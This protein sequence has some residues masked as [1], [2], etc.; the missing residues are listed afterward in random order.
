MVAF[1]IGYDAGNSISWAFA[2]G[3]NGIAVSSTNPGVGTFG[4]SSPAQIASAGIAQLFQN[5]F[6]LIAQ[7]PYVK[8][9]QTATNSN[10]ISNLYALNSQGLYKI[11]LRGADFSVPTIITP[12]PIFLASSLG[13]NVAFTDFI[14]STNNNSVNVQFII[15]TTQG[16]YIGQDDGTGSLTQV[17]LPSIQSVHR[18]IPQADLRGTDQNNLLGSDFRPDVVAGHSLGEYSALVACGCLTFEDGLN[19]VYQRALA[20]QKSCEEIP[21]TMA[22]IIGLTDEAVELVCSQVTNGIVVP[23]NYNCPGQLV[24]S[25]S[26]EA[27]NEAMIKCKELEGGKVIPLSVGGAF[28]SPLMASAATLLAQAILNTTFKTPACPYF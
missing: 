21:G 26:L 20:M 3:Q 13:P 5:P 14:A 19:L 2:A 17:Q 24:I 25:G 8:K 23:A 27:V 10:T 18:L 9:L 15:G 28:H 12:T 22:A 1:E 16:L 6:T 7:L 4:G 11:T